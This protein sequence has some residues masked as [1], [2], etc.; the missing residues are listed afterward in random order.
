MKN[1]L[2]F[3]LLTIMIAGCD[4]GVQLSNRPLGKA[5]AQPAL[6]VPFDLPWGTEVIV[7]GTDLHLYFEQVSE[8]SRCPTRAMCVWAGR[9]RILVTAWSNEAGPITLELNTEHLGRPV[10]CFEYGVSLNALNPYPEIPGPADPS[11]YVATLE[12][13]EP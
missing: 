10:P 6:F 11:D 9:A 4:S 1:G 13:S 3:M 8:E 12:V 7:K 5:D 2:C